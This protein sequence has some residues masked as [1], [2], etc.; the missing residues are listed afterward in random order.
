MTR[1]ERL[2]ACISDPHFARRDVVKH[3][4]EWAWDERDAYVDASFSYHG[5]KGEYCCFTLHL[6]RDRLE[7]HVVLEL[8]GKAV[9]W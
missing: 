1:Q 2:L 3:P 6:R 5:D 7:D 4:Q 9:R 8:V